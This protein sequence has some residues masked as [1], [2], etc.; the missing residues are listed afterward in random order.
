M[1]RTLNGYD[2]DTEA[3]ADTFERMADGLRSGDVLVDRLETTHM[4]KADA[5]SDFEF[6]MRYKATHGYVD[7]A[8]AIE[9]DA[10][11]YLRF[12]DEYVDDVLAGDKR[13]TMRVGF[14]RDFDV[15][16]I[17]D[18]IDEDGDKFAEVTVE[19]TTD[20]TVE[21][22]T[23]VSTNG[24]SM[25]TTAAAIEGWVETLQEHYDQEI[26]RDTVATAIAWDD[27]TPVED[28]TIPRTGE[29]E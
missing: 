7:V 21:D 13:V 2:V 24:F 17:V 9:Y 19:H 15:G 12:A 26:D 4:T 8:D 28:Y 11:H 25:A 1:V 3:L 10:T 16:D 6:A 27:V 29:S 22:V 20:G 14:E 18:L 23:A 5:S